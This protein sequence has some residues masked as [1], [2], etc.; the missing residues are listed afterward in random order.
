MD[1][2]RM[3]V[4]NTFLVLL[5]GIVLGYIV[6]D[7]AGVR[8]AAPYAGKRQTAAPVIAASE[9]D[10]AGF[11]AF[12]DRA[13][14]AGARPAGSADRADGED[15]E[16]PVKL[17]AARGEEGPSDREEAG[18]S[19][20]ETETPDG[21]A[22]PENE[23]AGGVLRGVEDEFFRNPGRF[24]GED[25]EMELQMLTA[26]KKQKGWLI[27]LARIK[28]GKSADY[29]YV[30]DEAVLGENPDLKIGFFYKTRFRCRKGDP[31][32][33]NTLLNLVPTGN[34]AVWATGVS[35]IE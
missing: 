10:D 15:F 5:I 11:S 25:L 1:F 13:A 14:D 30:E 20:A 7:R 12:K 3:R 18:P 29:L 28:S 2:F 19:R 24:S 33:G 9:P 35:A 4:L 8:A 6:K 27:N 17:P 32:A 16:L 31:A 22:V 34:K 23:K 26:A 21:T